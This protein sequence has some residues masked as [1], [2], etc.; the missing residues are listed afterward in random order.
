MSRWS[1]PSRIPMAPNCFMPDRNWFLSNH[2]ITVTSTL[3]EPNVML[4]PRQPSFYGSRLTGH[5]QASSQFEDQW[6]ESGHPGLGRYGEACVCVGGG[7][8]AARSRPKTRHN[9]RPIIKNT[10]P[11][12]KSIES[13][14]EMVGGLSS[15]YQ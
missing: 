11:N 14:Q 2:K 5:L 8:G 9:I 6:N 15:A 12:R 4:L 13:R 1:T 10:E 7:V 3:P